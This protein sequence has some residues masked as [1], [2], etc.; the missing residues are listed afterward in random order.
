MQENLLTPKSSLPL[1]AAQKEMMSCSL[2]SLWILVAR[3]RRPLAEFVVSTQLPSMWQSFVYWRWEIPRE[4]GVINFIRT[5]G[6]CKHTQVFQDPLKMKHCAHWCDKRP[7]TPIGVM[8]FYTQCS[9]SSV[10]GW[11]I[12]TGLSSKIW[13]R[14][15]SSSHFQY[16]TSTYVA[17]KQL[18]G[19]DPARD[20]CGQL[21]GKCTYYLFRLY[22]QTQS[23]VFQVA[24]RE[25][26]A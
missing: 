26:E 15:L 6:T 19:D 1:W 18:W 12:N 24:A 17:G 20:L 25:T 7:L 4:S 11:C 9:S 23:D 21:W 2:Y 14:D 13:L 5:R 3:R 22:D 8:L 10:P 16:G